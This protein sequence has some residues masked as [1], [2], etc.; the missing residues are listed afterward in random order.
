V[1]TKNAVHCSSAAIAG[2]ISQI[3]GL[4][5]L[6]NEIQQR[7]TRGCLLLNQFID[8]SWHASKTTNLCP[9]LRS[10]STMFAAIFPRQNIP[11]CPFYFLSSRYLRIRLFVEL[12]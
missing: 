1:T 2:T 5:E 9:A 8:Y 12:S 6:L 7:G 4:F 10:R 3:A 11:S